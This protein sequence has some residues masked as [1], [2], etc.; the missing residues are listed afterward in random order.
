MEIRKRN[1]NDVV[2]VQNRSVV[3]PIYMDELNNL[4]DEVNAGLDAFEV[5]TVSTDTISESTSGSGV[6]I[7]GVLLKDGTITAV[8]DSIT[9][10]TSV[11]LSAADSG[12][13]FYIGDS[14]AV[15]YILPA[16]SAGL[17]YKFIVIADET[18]AT[19]ITTSD[20]TDTT[21]EGFDGGLLVCAAAAVNT[22]IESGADTCRIT[23][24]DNVANGAC[25][26]GSWLE[27]IG[28]KAKTWFVTGVINSTTDADGVG[29]AI[30]SDVDA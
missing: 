25:G 6:T 12:K 10:A 9:A 17:K 27:I 8:K 14:S 19:T 22:F 15:D 13:V 20:T 24:D 3:H 16:C 7:D 29:S 28:V 18:D 26:K 11:T 5:P 21:G 4:I 30:F 1:I 23:L 2:S